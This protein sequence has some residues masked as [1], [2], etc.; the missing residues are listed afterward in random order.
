MPPPPD[1]IRSLVSGPSLVT[2]FEWFDV[3][4]STNRVALDAARQGVDEGYLVVA[5]VQT[6]GRGRLG[7]HWYAPPGTSV[8]LS[9]LLRPT[10]APE[11]FPLLTLLSGLALAE[12]T[13]RLVPDS[14]VSLKWPNDLLLRVPPDP[15][16]KAAGILLE[17]SDGAAVVGVGV[18]VDWRGAARPTS[19]Q[20]Q[21][22][23]LAEV[24]G[25][26]I[27]RWRVLAGFALAFSERYRAYLDDPA[28]FLPAYR[29]WCAT[30][31]RP[32]RIHQSG[33]PPVE[34]EATD[35]DDDGQLV[36]RSGSRTWRVAAGDVEHVET[37]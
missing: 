18:D 26:P 4:D 19:I 35:V 25:E 5:D 15:P 6:L 11:R 22:T 32:V 21:S 1:V 33:V 28:G 3:I 23:S 2:S 8:L 9:L 29:S 12:T 10:V 20:G 7:R 36:V 31:G 14:D 37:A 13:A 34:A 16:R 24:L 30:I 17:A 27:D